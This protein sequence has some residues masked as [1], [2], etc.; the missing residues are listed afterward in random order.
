[1]KQI[2]DGLLYD[3]E[4]AEFLYDVTP[5]VALYKTKN[6]RF[7][8]LSLGDIKPV[9]EDNVRLCLGKHFPGKYIELFGSVDEA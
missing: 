1:M 9:S 3:N 5:F 2:I 7:F 8:T 4:K 6:G